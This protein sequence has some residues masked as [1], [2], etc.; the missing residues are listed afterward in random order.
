MTGYPAGVR[1]MCTDRSGQ[2][3]IGRV[4]HLPENDIKYD[5]QRRMILVDAIS[6]AYPG[7]AYWYD[8]QEVRLWK[9]DP[10]ESLWEQAE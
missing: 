8:P 6:P 2:H 5:Y 10:V 4:R 1:V 7:E 3:M 9:P